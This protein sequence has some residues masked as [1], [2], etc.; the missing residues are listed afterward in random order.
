[1]AV[2]SRLGDIL[3]ADIDAV[4]AA[5]SDPAR[6]ARLVVQEVEDTLVE[7]RIQAARGIAELRDHERRTD[8]L[9]AAIADWAQKAEF[10]LAKDREDLAR[11]ALAAKKR[12]S[13]DFSAAE[14]QRSACAARTAKAQRDLKSLEVK[15]DEARTA[16]KRAQSARQARPSHEEGERAFGARA[17][18]AQA[19]EQEF[20]SSAPD[21]RASRGLSEALEDLKRGDDIERELEELRR[22]LIQKKEA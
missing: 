19:V 22:R 4:I 18:A 3:N 14:D 21:P 8:A 1:M 16:A 12:A 6:I 2:F 20:A 15:L 5:S 13:E 10:A 9:A 11:G 7:V 17:A